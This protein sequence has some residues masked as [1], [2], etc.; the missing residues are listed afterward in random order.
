M[1]TQKQLDHMT[2]LVIDVVKDYRK[3]VL[4]FHQIAGHGNITGERAK[5]IANEALMEVGEIDGI[6]S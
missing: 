1:A 5:Q 3:L 2:D 6:P 4:A